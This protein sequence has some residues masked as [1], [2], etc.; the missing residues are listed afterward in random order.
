M[1]NP[2]V[3]RA[4][5]EMGADGVIVP[6]TA[7]TLQSTCETALQ[8]VLG[9]LLSHDTILKTIARRK[10]TITL[11]GAQ[12]DPTTKTYTFSNSEAVGEITDVTIGTAKK[13]L[14]KF[15]DELD[16]NEWYYNNVGSDDDSA[17][18]NTNYAYGFYVFFQSSDNWQ[19][20]FVPGISDAT[21]ADI[22]HITRIATPYEVTMIEAN[23]H[24][25]VY[26][27]GVDLLKNGE[28]TAQTDKLIGLISRRVK[29]VKGGVQVIKHDP[30]VKAG[31]VSLNARYSSIF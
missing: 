9:H 4:H 3:V 24:N 25:L 20:T 18:D 6:P 15:V 23:L 14:H 30:R 31:V 8:I 19:I 27:V 29:P 26:L 13:P 7:D 10:T 21:S 2:A 11:S 1:Q 16:Y 5:S 12:W 22:W 28:L 17:D